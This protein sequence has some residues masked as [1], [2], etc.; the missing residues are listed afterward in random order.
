MNEHYTDW[1]YRAACVGE[2]P[3]LFF[4]IGGGG[5]GETQLAD[6]KAVC[7]RCPV[8]EQCLAWALASGQDFGVWGAMS[9]DE[10]RALARSTARSRRTGRRPAE[11]VQELPASATRRGEAPCRHAG[12]RPRH[13]SHAGRGPARGEHPHRRPLD[14]PA[15]GRDD[16]RTGR[17]GCAGHG[18]CG[19]NAAERAGCP[20]GCFVVWDPATGRRHCC[21]CQPVPAAPDGPGGA[22]ALPVA[23]LIATGTALTTTHITAAAGRAGHDYGGNGS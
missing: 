6:A 16:H 14:I 11:H 4:P 9:E 22:G 20:G 15:N 8:R 1:R 5:P 13:A 21:R 19:V 3:E 17:V 23:E 2:A 12:D 18:G 10:R 7:R